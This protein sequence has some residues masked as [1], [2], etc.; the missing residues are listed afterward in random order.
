MEGPSDL[1]RA[2]GFCAPGQSARVKVWRDQGERTVEVKIGEAPE[3]REL[4]QRQGGRAPPPPPSAR[5]VTRQRVGSL[6][7]FERLTGSLKEG[8]KL[9]MRLPVG[10]MLMYVAFTLG[11]G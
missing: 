2:V 5:G 10:P 3:E 4:Q 1:Q 9:T 7:D 6:G 11:R 8:D